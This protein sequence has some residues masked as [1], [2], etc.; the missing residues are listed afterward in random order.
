M[1]QPKKGRLNLTEV[2]DAL[3]VLFILRGVP[4]YIRSDKVPGCRDWMAAVS[5]KTAQVHR[6]RTATAKA[7]M[8]K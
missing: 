2:T 4:A 3:T 1:K 6:E 5:D 7:S 8:P